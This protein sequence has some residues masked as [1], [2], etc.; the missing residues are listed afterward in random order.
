MTEMCEKASV[1]PRKSTR[2]SL[3]SG[4][5]RHAAISKGAKYAILGQSVTTKGLRGRAKA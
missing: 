1:E 5:A 4:V 3:L 2:K